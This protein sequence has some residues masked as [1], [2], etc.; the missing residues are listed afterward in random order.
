MKFPIRPLQPK[1]ASHSGW[2]VCLSASRRHFAATEL[3]L[4]LRGPIG[5]YGARFLPIWSVRALESYVA[6][7]CIS[8][9]S[10]GGW[11]SQVSAVPGLYHHGFEVLRPTRGMIVLQTG[12]SCNLAQPIPTLSVETSLGGIPIRMAARLSSRA[13]L[14]RNTSTTQL[15]A[16][17]CD[18]PTWPVVR[19]G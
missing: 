2:S 6:M 18:P 16:S 13:S 4:T 8:L 7:Q 1:A 14:V 12:G 9:R 11:T 5:K 19:S 17:G 10:T 3:V 15:L